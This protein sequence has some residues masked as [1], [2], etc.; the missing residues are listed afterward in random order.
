MSG[1]AFK[2]YE[3]DIRRTSSDDPPTR[4][5]DT[6]ELVSGLRD[7]Y[8]GLD[9]ESVLAVI[10]SDVNA[11]LG[12]YEVSKG[13]VSESQVEFANALRPVVLMGGR[14]LILVHN[15]PSGDYTPSIGDVQ[16]AKGLFIAASLLDIELSDNIVLAGEKWS[17]VHDDPE[18]VRWLSE[19]LIRISAVMSGGV[20]TQEQLGAATQLRE[21]FNGE[22]ED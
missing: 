7:H 4:L 21:E 3:V 22:D 11:L 20:I 18:F 13:G 14:K 5:N 2:A 9:R 15:H 6:S 1:F 12:I 8:D 19:D 10:L 17:S 16:M